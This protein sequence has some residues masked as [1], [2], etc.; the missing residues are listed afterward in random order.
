MIE[1]RR[2]AD[3]SPFS[4]SVLVLFLYCAFRFA[5]TALISSAAFY[6][7]SISLWAFF[8]LGKMAGWLAGRQAYRGNGRNRRDD[9]KQKCLIGLKGAN[10]RTLDI[11]C[12]FDSVFLLQVFSSSSTTYFQN[13]FV[14]DN[15]FFSLC[16]T[17]HYP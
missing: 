2:R 1:G 14:F 13:V 9:Q 11:M 6:G 15:V 10:G 7:E 16:S 4:I 8:L 12:F 5:V 17:L 3:G